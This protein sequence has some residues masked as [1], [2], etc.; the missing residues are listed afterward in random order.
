MARCAVC[1]TEFRAGEPHPIYLDI[2]IVHAR[3]VNGAP[4]VKRELALMTEARDE[5]MRQHAATRV[6]L[7]RARQE[8]AT[9]AS[10]ISDLEGEL[11]RERRMREAAEAA[12]EFPRPL[13]DEPPTEE[14]SPPSEDPSVIRSGLLELD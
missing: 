4:A 7:Q 14:I 13:P 5:H 6:E 2:Y 8:N 12:L 11:A 9:M 10:M 3:C 1:L